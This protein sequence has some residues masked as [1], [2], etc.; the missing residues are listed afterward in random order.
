MRD[1]ERK[2]ISATD[3]N[4][5]KKSRTIK[6]TRPIHNLW[7]MKYS[8]KNKAARGNTQHS[9]DRRKQCKP[10]N[11]QHTMYSINTTQ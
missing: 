4:K 7:M 5:T 1:Q 2:G 10:K 8:G 6:S 3:K 11:N 9:S